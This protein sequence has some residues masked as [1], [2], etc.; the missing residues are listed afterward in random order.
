VV[1][2]LSLAPLDVQEAARKAMDMTRKH[3][4]SILN[5]C[6]PYTSRNEIAQAA[7]FVKLNDDEFTLEHHLFTATCPRLDML[8]RTSGE[9]RLSDYLL[10]QTSSTPEEACSVNF[11]DVLWP[12][13]TFWNFVPLLLDWQRS[14]L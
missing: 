7:E 3:D 14:R 8:V 13:F 10:W 9:V 4:K 6:F 12:D 1:G 2:D 11:I 5:I